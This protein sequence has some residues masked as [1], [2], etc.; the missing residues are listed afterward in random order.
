[1]DRRDFLKALVI[2]G[3]AATLKSQ[4]GMDMLAQTVKN[5][6]TGKA[7]DMVAVMGGEP[8]DMFKRAIAELG[9]MGKFVKKG[10]KVAVKPNIGWDRAPERAANTNP[11]LVA[12]VVRQC[13]AAGAKEVT[14]FDHSCDEWR[15]CY[16]NSGIEASAKAVGA[17]VI[18]ANEESDYR[19]ISL[20]NGK[21]LKE[22][23]V[24]KAILDSDVWINLPILKHHGGANLSISM[25]NLMGIVWDRRIFHSSDLHQCIADICTLQ[26]KPVLNIVDAYRIMKTNGPQGRSLTDVVE[27]K[28]LFISQDIVAV[29]T[30]ATKFFNQIRNMP[31]EHVGYLANG[32]SLKI[33]TMDI[34][35]LNVK[36]VSLK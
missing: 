36:K 14:V 8:V 6:G 28:S 22:A 3:A 11:E 18:P 4:G 2:S 30:A 19:T 9:G 21:K 20:P 23:K 31:L 35:K 33:G 27:S 32:Q 29:D 13:F 26:K 25:K 5:T 7:V 16:K 10:Y 24:H 1:M 12:E 34:D 15:K 17:N